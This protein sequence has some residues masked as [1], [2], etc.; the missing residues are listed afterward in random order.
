MTG[1]NQ[2]EKPQKR[3]KLRK[4]L[5]KRYF[6]FKRRL[7]WIKEAKHFSK[8]QRKELIQNI[9][10]EHSSMLLRP[11]KDVDMQ[12]Q[13]NKITN[14]RLAIKQI[15]RIVIHPRQTF[16]LWYL[17]GNPS[18]KRGYL[19]GLV[20]SNGQIGYDYGGGLC[21]LGNLLY[22]MLLHTP[23]TVTER[24]RHGFDVFPD[25]NRKLP[26]GSGATL[27][28]NYVDLQFRNDTDQAYQLNLF[29]SEE[30]LHGEIRSE[31]KQTDQYK[32]YED[33][34]EIKHQFWGGYTRHNRLSR[35]ITDEHENLIS[36]EVV[37]EN[38]AIMMYEPLLSE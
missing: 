5:G 18:K 24:W 30:R 11:L 1:T 31:R 36:D 33:Y 4:F 12:Y 16:S 14:L 22:W 20:L 17:V 10:I 19:K 2:V 32:V 27:S 8:E 37:V 23:L 6:I 7:R 29:L 28:Y 15:N 26:F 25:V 3:G 13:Y 38:H 21:Q 35:K 9:V 34:H